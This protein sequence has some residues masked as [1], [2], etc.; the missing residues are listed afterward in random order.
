MTMFQIMPCPSCGNTNLLHLARGPV[1]RP[2][3]QVDYYCKCA[4]CR[5]TGKSF[6]GYYQ[7]PSGQKAQAKAI[8]AWNIMVSSA[9]SSDNAMTNT[10]ITPAE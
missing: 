9:I 4:H 10:N 2:G 1:L 8:E 5:K 7:K 6:V 3:V